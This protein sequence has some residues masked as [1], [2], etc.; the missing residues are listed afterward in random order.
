[1]EFTTKDRDNDRAS[2]NCA[3]KWRGALGC[4]YCHNSNLN[5][6]Y[7]GDKKKI[8]EQS[9]GAAINDLFHLNSLK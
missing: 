3:V 1:M 8:A 2:N 4:N 9:G 6:Q 5:D 7:L